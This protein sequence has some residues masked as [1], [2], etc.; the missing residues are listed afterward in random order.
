MVPH[1]VPDED[2]D[3]LGRVNDSVK[4]KIN[5]SNVEII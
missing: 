4:I 5:H 1:H 3:R 2:S